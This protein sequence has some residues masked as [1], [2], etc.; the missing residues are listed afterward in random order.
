MEKI[1]FYS[2]TIKDKDLYY[3]LVLACVAEV[4]TL[5][6]SVPYDNEDKIN[7]GQTIEESVWELFKKYKIPTQ[8]QIISCNI[9]Q[10][11]YEEILKTENPNAA[12]KSICEL[13]NLGSVNITKIDFS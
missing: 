11:L 1:N 4:E 2:T 12:L 10:E 5:N 6:I 7:I 9:A 8:N 3:G 13:K